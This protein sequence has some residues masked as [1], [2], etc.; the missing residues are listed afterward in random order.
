M[1]DI[2]P[3]DPVP[4]AFVDGCIAALGFDAVIAGREAIRPYA[5]DFWGQVEGVSPLV[6]QAGNTGLLAGTVPDRSGSQAVL[7]LGRL[8]VIR[9]RLNMRSIAALPL[10]IL[11]GACATAP[12]RAPIK[13]TRTVAGS[14]A[15]VRSRVAAASAAMGFG[16]EDNGSSLR[17]S[18]SAAPE[19]WADCP[20]LI[21]RNNDS[22]TN[23]ADFAEPQA[24]LVTVEVGFAGAGAGTTVS[25]SPASRRPTSTS[26][27]ICRSRAH[28]LST[29]Q[30]ERQLLDAAG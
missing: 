1:L 6:P 20:V 11:L 14:P 5:V 10:L 2:P 21:V 9:E 24:R 30:V 23:R 22:D 7:S 18:R 28:V 25:V 15:E 12:P 27:A 8:G 4:A 17:L 26:I 29:G 19:E 16:V 13:S 3:A